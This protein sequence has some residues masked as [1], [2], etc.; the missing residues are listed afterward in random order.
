VAVGARFLQQVVLHQQYEQIRMQAAQVQ[1][2]HQWQPQLSLIGT[3][4]VQ[5][6]ATGSWPPL[7]H[8]VALPTAPGWPMPTAEASPQR[9]VSP[10][11]VLQRLPPMAAVRPELHSKPMLL[12]VPC[13]VQSATPAISAMPP[14]QPSGSG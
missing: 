11:E 4:H 13:G 10:T 7:A 5:T 9:M 12:P 2:M 8:G 14:A 1:W 3:S 6:G